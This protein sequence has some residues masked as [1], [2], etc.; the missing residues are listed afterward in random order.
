MHLIVHGKNTP[1]NKLE[2]N[3]IGDT[4]D[5][6]CTSYKRRDRDTHD[7]FVVDSDAYFYP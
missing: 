1:R 5:I 4:C 7:N 2:T 6:V 3:R